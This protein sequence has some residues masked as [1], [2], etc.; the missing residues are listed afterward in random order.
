MCSVFQARWEIM[1]TE[2]EFPHCFIQPFV[3]QQL[4]I[5][6]YIW[7]FFHY[8]IF[9]LW[10]QSG[11]HWIQ[12]NQI[13]GFMGLSISCR[14]EI[15]MVSECRQ[16][17]EQGVRQHHPQPW[18]PC[19]GGGVPGLSEGSGCLHPS[20]G[21]PNARDLSPIPNCPPAGIFQALPVSRGRKHCSVFCNSITYQIVSFA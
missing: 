1:C 12:K 8:L 21:E 19:R 15:R 11:V 2:W 5:L 4:K 14:T 17:S 20:Q 3:I 10:S 13:N 6:T 7:L 9:S 16:M 18:H